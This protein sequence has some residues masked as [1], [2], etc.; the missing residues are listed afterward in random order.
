MKNILTFILITLPLLGYG[1]LDSIQLEVKRLGADDILEPQDPS[2]IK[3]VTASRSGAGQSIS[4]LPVTIHVITKQEISLHG[5][6]TLVDVLKSVPGMKVSKPGTSEHGETFMMRGLLGNSYTKIL[7]NGI[8]IQP[9]VKGS[10]GIGEQL[11]IP[12]A[13]RIEIIYG[14]ASSVYGL[15]AMSGVINIITQKAD[16]GTIAH[17]NIVVGTDNYRHADFTVGGKAGK[18]KNVFQ[19][20]IYGTTAQREDQNID[21][22]SSLFNTKDYFIEQVSDNPFEG[23]SQAVIDF[24][25]SLS[26]EELLEFYRGMAP[27]YQGTASTPQIN[28]LPHESHSLGL[29]LNYRNFQFSFDEMYRKDHSTLGREPL[30]FSYANPGNF[31]GE[32]IRRVALSYQN[33]WE[34]FNLT[35]NTSYL[36][37]RLN[38]LS[39]HGVNY[40]TG[41]GSSAYLY[42]ASDDLFGEVL[43]NYTPNSRWDLLFGAAYQRSGSL[44][45]TNDLGSVFNV[46]E[47]KPFSTDQPTPH[48]LYGD[49][50]FNPQSYSNTSLFF[51]SFHQKDKFTFMGGLRAELSTNYDINN[52]SNTVGFAPVPISARVGLVYKVSKKGSVRIALASG[53]RAPPPS[54]VYSSLALPAFN[55]DG[56]VNTDSIDYQRIPNED[57]V[58]ETSASLEIGYR[59][60]FSERYYLDV[61]MFANTVSNSI[62]A[63][64][65][66]I[67]RNIYPLAATNTTILGTDVPIARTNLNDASSTRSISGLQLI[68]RGK[69]VL[70]KWKTSF[71]FYLTLSSGSENFPDLV[72]PTR[73]FDGGSIDELRGVPTTMAQFNLSFK[74]GANWYIRLENLWMNS[75]L[76]RGVLTNRQADDPLFFPNTDGFYNLDVVARYQISENLQG[77]VR[78]LNAFNADY[79]GIG[80]TGL[81]VDAFYN[82]QLKRNIQFGITFTK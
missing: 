75:W 25:N 8:P 35:V 53:F 73:T 3:V 2:D 10:I 6:T 37:Y 21:P 46:D 71:D 54:V 28:A 17:A 57:L 19:Y 64:L 79:G 47:Y 42:E 81:D 48:P 69:D 14:P 13:E 16:N 77:Y 55:D 52:L 29:K 20:L 39:S 51:Q 24:I 22:N 5:Y 80:A 58:P 9:S 45:I 56:T 60:T 76:R 32:R 23:A 7:I 72:L 65:V 70:P 41:F 63:E 50:G 36:R 68:F 1:Q 49:F 74:P 4:S 26:D 33:D 62:D 11:P 30:L 31:I 67:N 15:D 44:P 18:N 61:S 12:Q 66:P 38:P 59:H 34:K 78:V 82:P 43:L 40:F 27:H